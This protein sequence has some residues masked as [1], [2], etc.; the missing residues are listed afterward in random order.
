MEERLCHLG[1]TLF[2]RFKFWILGWITCPLFSPLSTAETTVIPVICIHLIPFTAKTGEVLYPVLKW[3][4]LDECSAIAKI[5]YN[6]TSFVRVGCHPGRQH[7]QIGIKFIDLVIQS[8]E[9]SSEDE[10]SEDDSDE[11]YSN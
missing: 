9:V 4:R 8:E 3:I 11:D 10:R 2:R 6:S 5:K 1:L 7:Y